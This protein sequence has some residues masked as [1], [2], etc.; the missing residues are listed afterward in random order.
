MADSDA[1][2]AVFVVNAERDD[3]PFEP[4][5]GHARHRQQ[6]FAGQ[7]TRLLFHLCDN[8]PEVRDE[9]DLRASYGGPKAR[10]IRYAKEP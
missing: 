5:V 1:D 6:Q 8:E 4:W 9:Q 3:C 7:E 2:S 10:L